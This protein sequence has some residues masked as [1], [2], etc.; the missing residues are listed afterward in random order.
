M[1][2]KAAKKKTVR[3][4][5]KKSG[6]KN[7]QK[8]KG[9]I[10]VLDNGQIQGILKKL[11]TKKEITVNDLKDSLAMEQSV[12]S[13]YLKKLRDY[14]LVIREKQGKHRLY[15]LNTKKINQYLDLIDLLAGLVG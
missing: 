11:K 3:K 1:A 4:P 7:L 9:L 12:V 14:K 5:H 2:R 15:Q 6:N 13:Q 10:Q 8:V